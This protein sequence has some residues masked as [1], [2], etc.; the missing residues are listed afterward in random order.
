[1]SRDDWDTDPDYVA[2]EPTKPATPSVV[3]KSDSTGSDYHYYSNDG[4]QHQSV[5]RG[6]ESST[7]DYTVTLQRKRGKCEK[8]N[9]KC[10]KYYS[11]LKKENP[12][13]N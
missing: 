7:A 4:D 10:D 6:T 11:K 2:Y 5:K 3:E 12:E 9:C 1:M 13:V 8:P